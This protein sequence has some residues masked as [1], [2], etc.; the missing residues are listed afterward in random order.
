MR[1]DADRDD[2]PGEEAGTARVALAATPSFL[3]QLSLRARLGSEPSLPPLP[4]VLLRL[5][6]PK[7][8][9]RKLL[10]LLLL[11]PFDLFEPAPPPNFQ[12][13][14]DL[15]AVGLATA[16][17]LVPSLR[18]CNGTHDTV[19][20]LRFDSSPSHTSNDDEDEGSPQSTGAPRTAT[21]LGDEATR[22]WL[23]LGDN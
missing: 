20:D 16:V 12:T 10:L 18:D 22:R 14:P 4:A 8:E 5:R 19:S 9:D 7:G 17:L 3:D 13:P 2:Q 15:T 6:T 23:C 21:L 1:G 11:F